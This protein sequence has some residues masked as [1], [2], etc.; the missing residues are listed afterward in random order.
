MVISRGFGAEGAAH[1]LDSSPGNPGCAK[2]DG[3]LARARWRGGSHPATRRLNLS[4][5][6]LLRQNWFGPLELADE[7]VGHCADPRHVLHALG[8]HHEHLTVG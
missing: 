7:R 1:V 8:A 3:T 2:S 6:A 5:F 4:E